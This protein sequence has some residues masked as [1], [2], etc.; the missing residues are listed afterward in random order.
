MAK[1]KT[2]KRKKLRPKQKRFVEEYLIDLNATQAAIRAGYSKKT[3]HSQ[4]QRLLKNVEISA[5]IEKAISERSERTQVTADEVIREYARLAFSD[6]LDYVSFGPSGVAIRDSKELDE[7]AARAIA[8]VSE[9]KSQS[10]GSIKFKLHSKTE[11]LQALGRHLKLFVDRVEHSG[12]DGDG[13]QV[14]VIGGER[15]KF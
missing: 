14:I 4:G 13:V 12:P 6:M 2:K 1:K 15:I 8:E 10:G 11:A 3:A 9:S 7:D 5:M